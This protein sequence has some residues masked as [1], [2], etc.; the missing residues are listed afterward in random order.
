MESSQLVKNLRFLMDKRMETANAIAVSSG[1]KASTMMRL[2]DGTSAAP[3]NSTLQA[4]AMHFG[5]NPGALLTVD[6]STQAEELVEHKSVSEPISLLNEHEAFYL[7]HFNEADTATENSF[8]SRRLTSDRTWLPAPPDQELIDLIKEKSDDLLPPIFA[9]KV[10]GD[11]MAPTFRDGD[12]LYVRFTFTEGIFSDEGKLVGFTTPDEIKSGDFVLAYSSK[13]DE[14]T[15]RM[16]RHMV[17]RQ[18]CP[19][20]T[21]ENDF[22]LAINPDWPGERSLICERL[23]GKIVGRYTKF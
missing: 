15:K 17:V 9:F 4:L 22:L 3:R 18:F 5:V 6:L 19:D 21:G 2:L 10:N 16:R 14:N 20:D 1:I 12:V 23:V 13:K 7:Y 11:A 8:S